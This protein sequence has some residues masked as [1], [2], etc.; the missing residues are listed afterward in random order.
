MKSSDMVTATC[1]RDRGDGFRR[2]RQRARS[3][4]ALVMTSL[5]VA[6]TARAQ[7]NTLP[8]R[9]APDVRATIDRLMDSVRAAGLP[10]G[11]LA[12]KAAEGVLKG[13]DDQRIL[14]AVRMLARE[15]G[16]ARTILGS[17]SDAALLS[18]TASALHAG[19]APGEL[20]RI[21]RPSG[22]NRLSPYGRYFGWRRIRSKS[23][24]PSP[25]PAPQAEAKRSR[26]SVAQR[27][28]PNP[29]SSRGGRRGEAPPA[30]RTRPACVANREYRE[31]SH[32][33]SPA[34]PPPTSRWAPGVPGSG[35][36]LLPPPRRPLGAPPGGA[37]P[38]RRRPGGG[39][40]PPCRR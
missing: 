23:K 20:R 10:T 9:L 34:E 1:H 38:R 32:I 40:R 13:A 12:D 11:P 14:V 6:S 36:T 39:A 5:V 21:A 24:P 4:A 18:A 17:A 37:A 3:L 29:A 26:A 2:L 22:K 30:V 8:Q 19:A 7:A 15:L 35:I 33:R 16:E 27:L 31:G 25:G 28:V